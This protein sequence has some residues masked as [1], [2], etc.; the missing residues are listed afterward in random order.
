[1]DNKSSVCHTGTSCFEMALLMDSLEP[2]P[3][4]RIIPFLLIFIIT[5]KIFQIIFPIMNVNIKNFLNLRII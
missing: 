4:A 2:D 3:P 1:M 5:Y